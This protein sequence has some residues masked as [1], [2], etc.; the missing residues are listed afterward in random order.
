MEQRKIWLYEEK[1]TS[2][3]AQMSSKM[4]GE[5]SSEGNQLSSRVIAQQ[6]RQKKAWCL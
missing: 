4:W 1:Q 3:V 2:H 5:F 6:M